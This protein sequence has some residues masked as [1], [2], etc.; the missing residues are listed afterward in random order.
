M[1]GIN[2]MKIKKERENKD[3]F[4]VVRRDLSTYK[5]VGSYLSFGAIAGI[6]GCAIMLMPAVGPLIAAPTLYTALA[7]ST[8]IAG[9]ALLGA[10]PLAAHVGFM[11]IDNRLRKAE[12]GIKKATAIEVRMQEGRDTMSDARYAKLSRKRDEGLMRFNK[13]YEIYERKTNRLARKLGYTYDVETQTL[14]E[15]DGSKA[16]DKK[17]TFLHNR[18]L[19]KF[20]RVSRW[21]DDLHEDLTDYNNLKAGIGV[22]EYKKNIA[23][24]RAR[25]RAKRGAIH[26]YDVT[27][28][29]AVRGYDASKYGGVVMANA[30]LRGADWTARHGKSGAKKTANVLKKTYGA[31]KGKLAHKDVAPTIDDS[32][33]YT[34]KESTFTPPAYRLNP[35]D[36]MTLFDQLMFSAQMATPTIKD[37]G[38]IKYDPKD[39]SYHVVQPRIVRNPLINSQKYIESLQS[40]D[41]SECPYA[42]KDVSMQ[43]YANYYEGTDSEEKMHAILNDYVDIEKKFADVQDML[44]E[45]SIKA[46]TSGQFVIQLDLNNPKF[47]INK[48]FNDVQEAVAYTR[49]ANAL[50][51]NAYNNGDC[52]KFRI[53]TWEKE[54]EGGYTPVVEL[55]TVVTNDKEL[56]A[57]EEKMR[58]AFLREMRTIHRNAY[59]LTGEASASPTVCILRDI[60]NLANGKSYKAKEIEEMYRNLTDIDL[61]TLVGD[62][63]VNGAEYKQRELEFDIK[64][65]SERDGRTGKHTEAT[66]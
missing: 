37:N 62:A 42:Y 57:S 15:I 44:E 21:Y 30:V 6:G 22:D 32:A 48:V 59:V 16:L 23:E 1:N 43:D 24:N 61:N 60:E 51:A 20:N 8:N 10:T 33:Y 3:Y 66:F 45:E 64:Q 13:A 2:L 26:G 17:G 29:G 40:Q 19:K 27:K 50:G 55:S 56:E 65:F 28:R 36:E 31:V 4:H 41:I 12:R 54:Q 53:T 5:R 14:N 38:L 58:N 46:E 39:N 34:P 52:D 49:F 11:H 18:R 35:V 63:S 25:A 47:T 7:Y 9:A